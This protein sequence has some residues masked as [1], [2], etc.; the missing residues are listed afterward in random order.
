MIFG[1]M[2]FLQSPKQRIK[3]VLF[4]AEDSELLMLGGCGVF[5]KNV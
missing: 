2:Q 1:G 3:M 4:L 5:L